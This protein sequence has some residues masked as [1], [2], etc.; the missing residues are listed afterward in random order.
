MFSIEISGADFAS[1][2]LWCVIVA[3]VQS[4]KIFF[5]EN[6]YYSMYSTCFEFITS[7]NVL[8]AGLKVCL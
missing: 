5:Y 8:I 3:Q 1:G 7:G 2:H 4:D 6:N